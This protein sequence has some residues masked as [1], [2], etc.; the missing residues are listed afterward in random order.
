VGSITSLA[1]LGITVG[2]DGT[3]S[4]NTDQL[5]SQLASNPQAVQSFFSTANAGLSA[6]FKAQIDQLAGPNQSLLVNQTTALA[7]EI[8]NNTARIAVLNSKIS[9]DQTRLTAEFD[10]AELVVSELQANMNALSAI[11]GFATIGGQIASSTSLDN[12]ANTSSGT[13][14]S[15]LGSSFGS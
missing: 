10:N 11:Q 8:A 7:T 9:A 4:L 5:E 2:Q 13:S 12:G 14:S 6:K 3:L 15:N 1:A